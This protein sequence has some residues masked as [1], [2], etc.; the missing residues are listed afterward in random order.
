[1]GWH[2]GEAGIDTAKGVGAGLPEVVL[3][4]L[5][6]ERAAFSWVNPQGRG[7]GF[8]CQEM[9]VEKAKAPGQ[10]ELLCA[11]RLIKVTTDALPCNAKNFDP[12]QLPQTHITS[13]LRISSSQPC[14]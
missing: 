5:T 8:E 3:F 4:T 14:W 13:T 10:I 12:S 9:S 6:P 7:V 1:M 2:K 11:A